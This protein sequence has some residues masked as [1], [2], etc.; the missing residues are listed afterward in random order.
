MSA[1]L[2]YE[3]AIT[4]AAIDQGHKIVDALR[5]KLDEEG[6]RL[7]ALLDEEKRLRTQIEKDGETE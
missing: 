6:A 5:Q 7:S 3:L 4:R 2:K 1:R